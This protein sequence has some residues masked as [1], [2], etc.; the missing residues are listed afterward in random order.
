MNRA[1]VNHFPYRI[2]DLTV[3]PDSY[4]LLLLHGHVLLEV[5]RLDHLDGGKDH[6]LAHAQVFLLP[7][8][9]DPVVVPFQLLCRLDG[10][11]VRRC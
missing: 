8:G 6:V 7:K 3:P 4:S 1:N 10:F 11:L 2:V 9:D 5:P